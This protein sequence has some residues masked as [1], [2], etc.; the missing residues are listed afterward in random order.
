MK[1]G[2]LLELSGTESME[3][4]DEDADKKKR[5]RHRHHH[6]RR[7]NDDGENG[8][9]DVGYTSSSYMRTYSSRRNKRLPISPV[10]DPHDGG[11]IMSP[12]LDESQ[13]ALFIRS[14][15][16][17]R[18]HH[19]RHQHEREM[20]SDIDGSFS[21]IRDGLVYNYSS[22]DRNHHSTSRQ[23]NDYSSR[24]RSNS[25]NRDCNDDDDDDDEGEYHG[26]VDQD[27]DVKELQ[28]VFEQLDV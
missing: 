23:S 16:R 19:S 1:K 6:H 14:T 4:D 8:R 17:Q 25:N 13:D 12:G 22:R 21:E 9:L 26:D 24:N 2:R 28:E 20:R 27:Q 7:D 18:R 11:A 15:R 3:H 10:N 5:Y